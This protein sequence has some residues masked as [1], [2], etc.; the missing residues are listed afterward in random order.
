MVFRWIILNA[1]N[2]SYMLPYH[3]KRKYWT[4]LLRYGAKTFFI[5]VW[6][7]DVFMYW[8]IIDCVLSNEINIF[9]KKIDN[10]HK[11]INPRLTKGGCCNPLRVFPGRSKT[12][13]KVTKGIKEI[14][15]TSFAVIF[16]KKNWGYHL[17]RG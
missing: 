9:P 10:L 6:S 16:M 5:T 2:N 11:F 12:P 13:K 3:D 7:F 15:F 14:S 4:M 8:F 1:H 17:T